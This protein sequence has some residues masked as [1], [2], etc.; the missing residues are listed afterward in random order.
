ME[1]TSESPAVAGGVPKKFMQN[2]RDFLKLL[3]AGGS[4]SLILPRFS[5]GQTGAQTSDA[6]WAIEY[7]K[8]LARIKAPK[9]PKTD[10]SITK[11]GAKAGGATDSTAAFRNAVEACHRA[12]GGRVVVP[13]GEFT[14]GAIHLKSNV[15]LHISKGATVKFSTDPKAYLPMVFT[16]WEGMEMMGYS[17][18]IY[19]FEQ[20]NVAVTG[21]GTLDGQAANENWWFWKGN[22]EDGWKPGQRANFRRKLVLAPAVYPA[23]SLQKRPYRRRSHH[24]FANVGGSSG[25]VRKRDRAKSPGRNARTEQ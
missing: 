12:G 22:K 3:L 21:E 13:A 18:L 10:F 20:T 1:R 4:A 9:F 24:R 25:V 5:F 15:N 8:I 11:Y 23:V 17:A 6:A 14:T 2:R 19:A 16:R 7:P